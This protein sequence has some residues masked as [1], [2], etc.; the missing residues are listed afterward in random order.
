M[1]RFYS[2]IALVMAFVFSANAAEFEAGSFSL[3][4]RAGSGLSNVTGDYDG[5]PVINF[6]AG[7][8]GDYFFTDMFYGEAGLL[9]S[10]KGT[11]IAS[12]SS[13]FWYLE[14]PILAGAKF[15][16]S[17]AVALNA[18]VG[19]YVAFGLFGDFDDT[20]T[21]KL[22]FGAKIQGGAFF[23]SF[24]VNAGYGYGIANIADVDGAKVH[25]SLIYVTVGYN[26]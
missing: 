8:V 25:N 6:H 23:N 20:N 11:E 14:M 16:V 1:K 9:L 24:S 15:N 7:A 19:P 2:L 3:G 4:V 10:K 17:D 21:K 13:D 12:V 5:D 18:Q 26:F 22:D